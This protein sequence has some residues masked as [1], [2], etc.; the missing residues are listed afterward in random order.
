MLSRIVESLLLPNLV[1]HE[2][3]VRVFARHPTP[4]ST[5]CDE[6][7]D[8]GDLRAAIV[9]SD[10]DREKNAR[11]ASYLSMPTMSSGWSKALFEWPLAKAWHACRLPPGSLPCW[12]SCAVPRHSSWAPDRHFVLGQSTDCIQ[13][14]RGCSLLWIRS[15]LEHLSVDPNAEFA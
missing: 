5:K 6:E 7:N 13:V 3:N 11:P 8:S 14:T 10:N 2:K 12:A 4:E 15:A 1:Q 9:R